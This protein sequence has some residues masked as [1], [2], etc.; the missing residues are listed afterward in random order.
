MRLHV[1]TA[2]SMKMF[3]FWEL[4]ALMMEVVSTYETSVNFCETA[5]RNILEEIH[6]HPQALLST[7]ETNFRNQQAEIL[8]CTTF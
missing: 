6:L 5:R 4:I 1:L 7:A 8:F 3:V 2:A